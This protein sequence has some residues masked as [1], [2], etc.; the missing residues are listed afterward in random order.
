ML[1]SC[2][3]LVGADDDVAAVELGVALAEEVRAAL[4]D[5]DE[6]VAVG[7]DVPD[8]VAVAVVGV[9]VLGADGVDGEAFWDP[10]VVRSPTV[11]PV[12]LDPV[13]IAETG[14]CP[15][16]SMPVTI[17]IAATNTAAAPAA[18]RT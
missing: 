1:L 15:I 3:A 17:T 2:G 9:V 10:A 4:E 6:V 11:V 12:E 13:T 5:D 7:S 16:S 18:R 8:G 14:R